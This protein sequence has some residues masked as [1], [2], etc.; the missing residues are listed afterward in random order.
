MLSGTYLFPADNQ[1][2][3][4]MEAPALDLFWKQVKEMSSDIGSFTQEI[5]AIK[6]RI[7]RL[8][9]E[10]EHSEGITTTA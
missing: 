10:V 3:E 6:A 9:W 5:S 7:L 2:D 1:D 4:M 8:E